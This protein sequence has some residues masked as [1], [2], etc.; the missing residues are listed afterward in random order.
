MNEELFD[1]LK[2]NNKNTFAV[3]SSGGWQ[4]ILIRVEKN[5]DFDYLFRQEYASR[6]GLCRDSKLEYCGIYNKR[7]GL[8]Y[9]ANYN[10]RGILENEDEL[11]ERSAKKL[12]DRLERDVCRLVEEMVGND[13]NNLTVRTIE[14]AGSYLTKWLEDSRK[15]SAATNARRLYLNTSI[16]SVPEFNYHCFYAAAEWTENSLLDYILDP[17]GYTKK[18]ADSYFS[19]RQEDIL[20]QF[21]VNDYIKAQYEALLANPANPVH[22]IKK[23]MNAV[24][25]VEAKTVNVT[26]VKDGTEMTFKTE[27]DD[28]RRDPGT[29]YS[30]YLMVAADRRRFQTK[31]GRNADYFPAEITRITYGKS[32]LYTKEEQ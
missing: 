28:L 1:W 6:E 22:L 19:Q 11:Q 17:V 31:F 25:S 26:I 2:A 12:K 9:A 24:G 10:L 14:T 29:Y 7:D 3:P 5:K 15:Y 4:D 30:T 16:S 32:V 18:E 20:C 8:I 21:L 23:I 13:R 27:A